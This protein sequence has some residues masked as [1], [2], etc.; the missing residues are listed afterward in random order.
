MQLK[1]LYTQNG[2]KNG[3]HGSTKS[4]IKVQKSIAPKSYEII[5]A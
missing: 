5:F 3:F 2:K 4:K 1:N